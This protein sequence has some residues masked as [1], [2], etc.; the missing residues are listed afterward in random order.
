M[1]LESFIF[2]R[3]AIFPLIFLLLSNSFGQGHP[4]IEKHENSLVYLRVF[5]TN[6]LNNGGSVETQ[7]TEGTGFVV[8]QDGS[9]G[10][11][12]TS[13]HLVDTNIYKSDLSIGKVE[14]ESI[15]VY[16]TIGRKGSI[17]DDS[18]AGLQELQI[19]TKGT[20]KDLDLMLLQFK[21]LPPHSAKAIAFGN[22]NNTT[23]NN[24]LYSLGYPEGEDLRP[25]TGRLK[26]QS[27]LYGYWTTDLDL[28]R[29]DS[30]SP[31]F[32][33]NGYAIG[34]VLERKI[35]SDEPSKSEFEIYMI[36][37]FAAS[38]FIEKTSCS[39]DV[40]SQ[41]PEYWIR[42]IT[43][44]D[45]LDNYLEGFN[46]ANSESETF[47]QLDQVIKLRLNGKYPSSSNDINDI[48]KLDKFKNLQELFL[49]NTQVTNKSIQVLSKLTNLRVLH[50]NN[51]KISNVTPLEGLESLQVLYLNYSRVQTIG[52][53]WLK[54]KEDS[55]QLRELY[56][57]HTPITKIEFLKI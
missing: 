33:R 41:H 7:L 6:Q 9:N 25:V 44:Q 47:S 18:K 1:I 4:L 30:G 16:G 35:P 54:P 48:A 8:C 37:M 51:T 24:D 42:E 39:Y 11:V 43:S 15:S 36:P 38:D 19:I 31:I 17:T 27:N 12:L 32:D 50:L 26:S 5:G 14:D 10:Y 53:E 57:N 46:Q 13:A 2:F 20:T 56:L 55:S 3:K 34:V 45:D 52:K 28:E 49:N 22:P 21:G 29:G 40:F 23:F